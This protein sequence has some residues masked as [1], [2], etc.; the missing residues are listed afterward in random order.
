MNLMLDNLIGEVRIINRQAAIPD[1]GKPLVLLAA[2]GSVLGPTPVMAAMGRMYIRE[3]LGNEIVG[4]YHHRSILHIPLMNRLFESMGALSRVYDL[5]KFV[6][7]LKSGRVRIAGNALEGVSCLFSWEEPVGPFQS[8]G[9]IAAAILAGAPICLVAH[10][11]TGPW[12][13][14]VELPFGLTIPGVP[15]LRG[16]NVPLPPLRRIKRLDVYC[17]RYKPV[18][19]RKKFEKLDHAQ[20]RA[21]LAREMESIRGQQ[22]TM[23]QE[24]QDGKVGP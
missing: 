13:V 2:H 11:G 4:F 6:E 17:R 18:V 14:K 21:A 3:G 19:S 1:E 16:V 10:H 23:M 24:L 7:M 12:S 20:R 22:N 8:A 15:G 9:M 5:Q